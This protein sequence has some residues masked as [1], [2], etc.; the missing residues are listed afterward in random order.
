MS[1]LAKEN[2]TGVDAERVGAVVV[3]EAQQ[4]KHSLLVAAKAGLG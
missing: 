4:G 3:V 2:R 1:D